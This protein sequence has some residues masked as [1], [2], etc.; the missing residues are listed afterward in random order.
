M[1]VVGVIAEQGS[2][3]NMNRM[4]LDKVCGAVKCGEMD[5]VLVKNVTR[6][7]G[8]GVPDTEEYVDLR[9]PDSLLGGQ[10]DDR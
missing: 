5:S 10:F 4:R 6:L 2:S 7:W 3:L 1:T 9:R 8:G